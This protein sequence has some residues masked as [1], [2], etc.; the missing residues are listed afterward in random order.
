MMAHGILPLVSG[1]K[2]FLSGKPEDLSTSIV[3]ESEDWY[4]WLLAEQNQAFTFQCTLGTFTAHRERKR[5]CWYLYD[6]RKQAGEQHKAYLGKAEKVTL[7][8]LKEAAAVL[9]PNGDKA[10]SLEVYLRPSRG[11]ISRVPLDLAN[12][13][14]KAFRRPIPVF[15]PSAV[16]E[17]TSQH[18]LPALLTPLI[19]REQEVVRVCSFLRQTEV[20]LLTLTGPGGVGKTRL[21]L[22]IAAI[23]CDDFADGVCFIPLAP[24]S[25]PDMTI[26][27]IARTLGIREATNQTLFGLLSTYLHEK[28]ILLFL[29]NFEQVVRAAP[30][31]TAL[32]ETCPSVKMLVSSREVLHV[33]GELEFLV[34]PLAVPDLSHFS[35]EDEV[36]SQYAAVALFVQRAQLVQPDF[37]ITTANAKIIAAI[38]TRLDGLPLALELAASRIRLLSPHTLLAHLEHRLQI[39]T[40]GP[41]DVP[42]RQQT[43]RNTIEW[44]YNLLNEGEQRLF[45]RFSIFANGCTLEAIEAVSTTI[46]GEVAALSVLNSAASL[47][48]KSLLHQVGREGEEARLLMLETIREYGLES[49]K[50]NNE[51][52]ITQKAHAAYYLQFSEKIEPYL[53][54]LEQIRWLAYL[55]QE[56]DNLRA[57]LSWLFESIR[58]EKED[59]KK[60][61]LL[62]WAMRFC[63]ALHRFWYILGYVREGQAFLEQALT[64]SKGIMTLERAKLL[65]AA[66]EMAC[67]QGNQARADT[68]GQESLALYDALGNKAGRASS[69]DQLGFIALMRNNFA[70]ARL[71]LEAAAALF[72]ELRDTWGR[73]GCLTSLARVC[74]TQGE[75]DQARA[76]LEESLTL[77]RTVSDQA[78]IGGVLYL[79]AQVLFLSQSD[80]ARAQVISEQSMALL[81]EVG[82]KWTI[83]YC[84]NLTGQMRLMQGKPDL[85]RELVEKSVALLKEVGD[86]G[87]LVDALI[88]LAR[89]VTCQGNIAAAGQLYEESLAILR[90]VGSSSFGPIVAAYLEGWGAMVAS[91]GEPGEAAR[92]WGT[93]EALREA[94]GAPMPPVDRNNYEQ[95]VA[96][97][98]T[99][100]EEQTFSALW[101]QGR[102]TT[103]EQALN[104]QGSVTTPA[105]FLPGQSSFPST[106]APTTPYAEKLTPRETEVLRLLAQGLTN[107]QIANQLVIS[108]PTVNTHVGSVFNKLGV[109]TRS[110]ATRYA[111]EHGLV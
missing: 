52:E 79:L 109:N 87:A 63:A 77:Y 20:R 69:L 102:S 104:L 88:I 73:A 80:L 59:E 12:D 89:I 38:C 39:L 6:Y 41:R 18:T 10:S 9:V 15:D 50:A 62:K 22:E 61:E 107:P 47:L 110:A 60:T 16:L 40:Q 51:L 53:Q 72:Q 83:G 17:R 37:R 100:L 4:T 19:G 82:D 8:R 35:E 58:V 93:A 33:R 95:M 106:K 84:L 68:L 3:A 74:N 90:E 44:S 99:Q 55:Q 11:H 91:K 24:I 66:S 26:P 78:R 46:E 42:E 21:G 105:S 45:R 67:A 81:V 31:L 36:V 56:H 108:L 94:I 5:R 97:V 65:Y 23:L 1:N 27:T 29:D 64:L 28:Q 34:Q 25:D 70:A 85:A 54:G 96:L 75:Y 76:L 2:L 13:K 49:L 32:L 30:L 86:R 43:L 101:I 111:V 48:D 7:E 92:I 98:H 57:A 14:E 71:Q 103:P